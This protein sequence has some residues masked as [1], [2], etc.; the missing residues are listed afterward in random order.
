MFILSILLQFL[1]NKVCN[2]LVKK[3]V[4][5]CNF[6]EIRKLNSSSI[7]A[8]LQ[9]FVILTNVY[10]SYCGLILMS[11]YTRDMPTTYAIAYKQFSQ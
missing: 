11:A 7:V 8:K 2:S 4:I 5:A 9:K 1:F 3:K 10:K 6:V